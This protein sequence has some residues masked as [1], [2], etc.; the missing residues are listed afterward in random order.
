M[1]TEL[2]NFKKQARMPTVVGIGRDGN[3]VINIITIII[4]HFL[5][6]NN[7]NLEENKEPNGFE[8]GFVLTALNLL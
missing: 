7:F 4:K 1:L 8:K 6:R 5:Y 3:F 2:Q